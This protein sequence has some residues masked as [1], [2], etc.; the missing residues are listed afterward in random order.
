[1]EPAANA[2]KHRLKVTRKIGK[3]AYGEVFKV[4]VEQAAHIHSE[5]AQT[6]IAVKAGVVL[7]YRRSTNVWR[8]AGHV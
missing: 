7:D 5:L 1:M 4:L 3:G 6:F 8:A 2:D